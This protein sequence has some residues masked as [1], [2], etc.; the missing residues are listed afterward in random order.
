MKY[1]QY[2][3][4]I[5]FTPAMAPHRYRAAYESGADICLVDL[6]DSVAEQDKQAA[7]RHAS[8]FFSSPKKQPHLRAVRINSVTEADGLLDLLALREYDIGPDVVLVPKVEAARDIELVE[9]VLGR[10]FPGL[11]IMALVETPR[12]VENAA[13]IAGASASLRALFFGAADYSFATGTDR[14]WDCLLSARARVVNGARAAGIEV[15][16]SPMFELPDLDS[17]RREAVMARK[18]GF[19]G[20]GVVHPKQIPLINQVFSPDEELLDL[21]RKIVSGGEASKSGVS[22]VDG[23]MVGRPFF[24]ASQRLLRDFGNPEGRGQGSEADS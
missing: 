21:A 2:C 23:V 18:L 17:L 7:R 6:E 15:I 1:T 19:S 10:V 3:R 24:E 4:S 5:L 22:V 9:S 16:D 13:A 11:E 14:S 20:K 12:G 8:S